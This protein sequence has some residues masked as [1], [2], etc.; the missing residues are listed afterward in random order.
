MSQTNMDHFNTK[1]QSTNW[2][3]ILNMDDLQEAFLVFHS[4]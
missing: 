1:L 3:D 2:N 4:G